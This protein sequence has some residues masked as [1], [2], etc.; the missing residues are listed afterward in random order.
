MA[1]TREKGLHP[2]VP[3]VQKDGVR[4]EGKEGGDLEGAA[5][6]VQEIEGGFEGRHDR[7]RQGGGLEG[8]FEIRSTES[9]G[10]ESAKEG[11]GGT[12]NG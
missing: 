7:T 5:V 6:V 4:G 8:L 9:L 10:E 3:V 1:E 2:M 12:A 11:Q